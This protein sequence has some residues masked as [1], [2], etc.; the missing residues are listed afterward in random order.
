MSTEVYTSQYVNVAGLALL[1]YDHIATWQDEVQ[2]IWR[3]ASSSSTWWLYDGSDRAMGAR[4]PTWLITIS[5]LIC[6]YFALA[7]HIINVVYSSPF[8]LQRLN[9]NCLGWFEFQMALP[10]VLLFNMEFMMTIR[11]ASSGLESFSGFGTYY[12]APITLGVS[13]SHFLKSKSIYTAFLTECQT[14]L[15]GSAF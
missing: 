6:R 12:V 10:M 13:Q 5:F 9:G 1:L 4:E 14:T 8:F 11:V 2:Y 15:D 7:G 3:Y